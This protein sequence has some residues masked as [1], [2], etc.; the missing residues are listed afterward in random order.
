MK[1]WFNNIWKTATRQGDYYTSACATTRLS[2]LQ[3]IL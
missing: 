2:L 1:K 3:G